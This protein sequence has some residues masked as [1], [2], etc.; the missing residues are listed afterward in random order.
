M[1][2]SLQ[3]AFKAYV[4]ARDY[5]TTSRHILTLCLSV[6]RTAIEMGNFVHVTNYVSKAETT[7]DVAS[8]S[9]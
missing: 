8:V 6:I 5:C 1:I 4:R 9:G 3:N 2:S 7:P